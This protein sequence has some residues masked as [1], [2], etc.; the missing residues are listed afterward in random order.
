MQATA[1]SWRGMQVLSGLNCC[2]PFLC[3]ECKL[4]PVLT[5]RRQLNPRPGSGVRTLIKKRHKGERPTAD[6]QAVDARFPGGVTFQVI[7][8]FPCIPLLL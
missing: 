1:G 5:S 3:R 2:C 7:L 6:L 8:T 4:S